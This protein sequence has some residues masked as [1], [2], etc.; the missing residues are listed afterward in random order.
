MMYYNFRFMLNKLLPNM[1]ETIRKHKDHTKLKTYIY[2]ISNYIKVPYISDISLCSCTF[3]VCSSQQFFSPVWIKPL[4]PRQSPN[5]CTIGSLCIFAQEETLYSLNLDLE[6]DF[7]PLGH[8]HPLLS[9]CIHTHTHHCD[10][11]KSNLLNQHNCFYCCGIWKQI[12]FQSIF[13]SLYSGHITI[14]STI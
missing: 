7:R 1:T 11:T 8:S 5:I 14:L 2:I 12:S 3:N 4:I 6:N 9:K 13:I 10:M